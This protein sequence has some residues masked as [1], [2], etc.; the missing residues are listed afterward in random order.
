MVEQGQ[1]GM[2]TEDTPE[3]NMPTHLLSEEEVQDKLTGVPMSVKCC[4]HM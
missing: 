2:Y 4:S 3:I 1:W